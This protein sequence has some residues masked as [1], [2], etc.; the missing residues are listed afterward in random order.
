MSDEVPDFP[1][2][3]WAKAAVM[4]GAIILG[5]VLITSVDF[6]GDDAPPPTVTITGVR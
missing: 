3:R 1:W 2:P 4:L 5:L 6:S